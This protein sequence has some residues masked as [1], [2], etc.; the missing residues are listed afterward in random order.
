MWLT[1]S[2]QSM[3]ACLVN[4]TSDEVASD[5]GAP[6]SLCVNANSLVAQHRN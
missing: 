6:R 1:F 5:H 3:D 4:F 2:V